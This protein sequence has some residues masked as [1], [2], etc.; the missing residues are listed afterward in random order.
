MTYSVSRAAPMPRRSA[1]RTASSRASIH[2]DLNAGR[3]DAEER[4][5]EISEANAVL[6]D[7]AKRALY[8]E[9]GAVSLEA[10]FDAQ[11]ARASR[12]FGGGFGDAG[13]DASASTSTTCWAACSAVADA[14][15]GGAPVQRG[16]ART[17]N[18]RSNSSSSKPRAAAPDS[19]T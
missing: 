13:D 16:T 8:D 17:S 9:F 1:R 11:A 10:G 4:F 6:S 2:P 5:K 19:S 7:P 14:G 12:R 15:A 3:R 18:S